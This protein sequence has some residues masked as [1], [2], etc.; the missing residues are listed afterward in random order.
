[1]RRRVREINPT[2]AAD[3]D[4]RSRT[5]VNEVLQLLL[6]VLPPFLLFLQFAH[7]AEHDVPV[8][9]QLRDEEPCSREAR[10]AEDEPDD[11]FAF[12]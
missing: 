5:G 12:G 7:V 8:P 11:G 1:M 3:G 6:G 2:V 4:D 9:D 10:R